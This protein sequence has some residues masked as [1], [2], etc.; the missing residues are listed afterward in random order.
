MVLAGQR[1]CAISRDGGQNWNRLPGRISSTY[2]ARRTSLSRRRLLRTSAS[3]LLAL[4][5]GHASME[6]SSDAGRVWSSISLPLVSAKLLNFAATG[7]SGGRSL[8]LLAM[9]DGTRTPSARYFRSTDLG[10]Y[11]QDITEVFR[12]PLTL[13]IPSLTFSAGTDAERVYASS[14]QRDQPTWYSGDGGGSWRKGSNGLV[15]A[16]TN[17][18]CGVVSAKETLQST[19]GGTT[20]VTA[21]LPPDTSP[22]VLS[23]ASFG[24]QGLGA[25]GRDPRVMGLSA[26][27]IGHSPLTPSMLPVFSFRSSLVGS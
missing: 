15:E 18:G 12:D 14:S 11:W 6:S 7:S 1:P 3:G 4:F 16:V 10:I 27:P 26:R 5:G 23:V 21:P 24:S 19:C 17:T 8:L 2:R 25:G 20:L 9:D 22:R 13:G